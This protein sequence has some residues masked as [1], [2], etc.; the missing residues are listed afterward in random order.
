MQIQTDMAHLKKISALIERDLKSSTALISLLQQEREL[1]ITRQRS[2]LLD[3]VEQKNQC[4][5]QLDQTRMERHVLLTEMGLDASEAAWKNLVESL[6]ADNIA[7]AWEKLKTTL[8][9]CQHA[10]A[11]NGKM[12]ARSRA[13]MG[14]LLNLLRGQVE[15]PELYT[16]KGDTRGQCDSST[17]IQA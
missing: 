1:M 15:A 8:A 4:L 16:A 6:T 11:V 5:S 12:L 7:D 3:V 9:D 14:R 17:S 2:A 13:S 10:N